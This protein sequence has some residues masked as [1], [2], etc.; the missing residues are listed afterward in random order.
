MEVPKEKFESI[1]KEVINRFLI[2]KFNQL[3]MNASGE[4]L[5]SLE[6]DYNTIR[7]RKYTEQ[8]VNGRRG[9]SMPPINAIEDWVKAKFGYSGQNAKSMA[10]AVAK[11]IEKKGTSWHKKGGS[12]LLE[13]LESSECIDFINNEIGK[14]LKTELTLTFQREFQYI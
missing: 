6:V 11:S 13:V 2:P 3:G 14:Y 5:N 4:W 9:G 7:G 10:W 1:L 12:D 8:L